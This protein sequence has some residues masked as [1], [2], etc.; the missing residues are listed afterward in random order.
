M[1]PHPLS[2][3]L[4]CRSHRRYFFQHFAHLY[5]LIV[6]LCL[7]PVPYCWMYANFWWRFS[8]LDLVGILW[9]GHLL[10]LVVHLQFFRRPFTLS[11]WSQGNLFWGSK[12]IVIEG[13][14]SMTPQLSV[15]LLHVLVEISKLCL[16]TSRYFLI[17]L[18]VIALLMKYDWIA[19]SSHLW[20]I[21]FFGA[22]HS[23]EPCCKIF[24]DFYSPGVSGWTCMKT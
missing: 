20:H 10:Y 16:S 18:F 1:G 8:W 22:R 4:C 24:K 7:S 17:P 6:L 23:F 21:I 5:Q 13:V 12:W 11:K 2:V 19:L 3:Q 9:W 14:V 15:L